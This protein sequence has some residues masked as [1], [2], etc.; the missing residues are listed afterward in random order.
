MLYS[1]IFLSFIC[2]VFVYGESKS[3][4]VT[5]SKNSVVTEVSKPKIIVE[6]KKRKKR[7]KK[8]KRLIVKTVHKRFDLVYSE[9]KISIKDHRLDLELQ[10]K[11]CNSHILDSFY[12]ELNSLI[13]TLKT[14]AQKTEKELKI[15]TISVLVGNE[16]YF[17]KFGSPIGQ[18]FLSLPLEMIR[19][20]KEEKLNCTMHKERKKADN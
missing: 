1:L 4:L 17:I 13:N 20:K 9:R 18:F 15:D 7:K 6:R 14:E 16:E 10:R 2:P 19:M 12:Y 3:D 11:K 8:T 5:S